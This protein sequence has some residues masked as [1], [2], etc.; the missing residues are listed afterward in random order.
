MK[1]ALFSIGF[2]PLFL[3]ATL[4]SAVLMALWV[5]FY[6]VHLPLKSFDYYSSITWH[7]H[8]MIFGYGMA[9]VAGFLLTAIG[10][11]TRIQTVSG[12][13]LM[14]LVIAWLF[15]RIA[16]FV[17]NQAWLIAVVDMLFLPLLTVFVAIPLV[18]A[19]NK[20]NYFMVGMIVL[21][22]VLN[23]LV[24]FDK[25]GVVQ[26]IATMAYK[27]AFY[28][29]IA[30]IIVMAGRVFP[31]FSQN[32]VPVRYQVVKYPLVEQLV[33]PS[34]FVFMVS[35]LF[36]GSPLLTTLTAIVAA[37]INSIRLK[38]W[39]NRQ[40]WQVPLVWVLHVG[41]LFLIVG[42]VMTAIS[43]YRPSLYFL[44]L[45]A[46]SIGTL[47][48]VTIG[49]MARVS[50]G[51][52]GRDLRFPPK[53]IKPAFLLLVL[54]TLVRVFVP[55]IVPSAYQLTIIISGS[56]WVVA[57]GLFVLSYTKIFLSPRVDG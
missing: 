48:I 22:S 42:L 12:T 5:Y 16:P 29:I 11:W 6:G 33:M 51:H 49:M 26:N 14:L 41:Y 32:G 18:K 27:T 45:H 31:M 28:I 9:V 3:I 13:G 52:T 7:A 19:G 55:L 30:L 40:I 44:A 46:F 23:L 36:I 50:V 35:F 34:Y 10:N 43:Q 1:S 25:L 54:A 21:M 4:F 53:L 56:L 24:H 57:F 15:G 39:Y 37:T 38:G 8:E 2:R 20:R 47:G 17:L